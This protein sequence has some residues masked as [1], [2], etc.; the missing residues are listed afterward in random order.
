MA[1]C[2][3]HWWHLSTLAQVTLLWS[4][5]P[6][7]YSSFQCLHPFGV[8]FALMK[9]TFQLER[10]YHCNDKKGMVL[11]A[12]NLL[13][14]PT[15]RWRLRPSYFWWKKR[16]QDISLKEFCGPLFSG[17]KCHAWSGKEFFG[18]R[19]M[20]NAKDAEL[21]KITV[22][23]RILMAWK[24]ST[25]LESSRQFFAFAPFARSHAVSQDAFSYFLI[26]IHKG[27]C[28]KLLKVLEVTFFIKT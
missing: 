17:A 8:C 27:N 23:V 11:I 19:W 26:V 25:G 14:I 21:F 22:R 13:S 15:Y 2:G 20:W 10:F 5:Q 28:S 1:F 18:L 7:A 12:T 6:Q 16:G 3:N 9:M 24:K 4:S